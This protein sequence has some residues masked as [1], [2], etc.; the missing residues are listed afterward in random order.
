[1]ERINKILEENQIQPYV[2]ILIIGDPSDIVWGEPTP[3]PDLYSKSFDKIIANIWYISDRLDSIFMIPTGSIDHI[4]IN[5][6]PNRKSRKYTILDYI[7]Y[8][9]DR[10]TAITF[11]SSFLHAGASTDTQ[12]ELETICK[13]NNITI[14]KPD[15]QDICT[16]VH[17][18]R[19]MQID[20]KIKAILSQF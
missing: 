12:K 3:M 16:K 13:Q 14:K 7:K 9:K 5:Y 2:V 15:I 4:V 20:H 18:I 6:D 10:C 19:K 17:H 1:M 11:S 8:A